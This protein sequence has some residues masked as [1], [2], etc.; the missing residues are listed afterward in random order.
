MRQKYIYVYRSYF[1]L[2]IKAADT[3]GVRPCRLVDRNKLS[4]E[5]D[6]MCLRYVKATI[7]QSTRSH[8]PER[9]TLLVS[10]QCKY[11]T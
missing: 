6:A 3:E 5:F 10:G 7:Y 4:K 9:R 1:Y 8:N 2:L 11:T